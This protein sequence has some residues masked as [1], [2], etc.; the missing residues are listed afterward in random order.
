VSAGAVERRLQRAA[1]RLDQGLGR[2]LLRLLYRALARGYALYLRRGLLGTSVYL[3][4][5]MASGE[6]LHGLSDIDLAVIVPGGERGFARRRIRSRHELARR[7]L[8]LL[9]RFFEQPVIYDA[10][11][12]CETITR[13]VLTYGLDDGSASF[14]GLGD[15]HDEMQLERPELYGSPA[16]WRPL[17]GPDRRPARA[18]DPDDATCR[19][20]AWLELQNLW[21]WAFTAAAEPERPQNAYLCVKLI[22][23]GARIWLW[24]TARERV[25]TRAE[26]LARGCAELPDEAEAFERAR[27]LK[28][29]L[30]AMPRAPLAEFLPPFVRLSA[31]IADELTAQMAPAGSTVVRLVDSAPAGLILPHGGLAETGT[32]WP[33][34]TAGPLLALADFRALVDPIEPDETFAFVDGDPGHPETLRSTGLAADRG[35]YPTLSTR[36][37]MIRPTPHWGR[38]RLRAIQCEVSDPVSFALAAG[39]SAA[40]FPNVSGFSIHDTAQ[41]ALIEHTAWLRAATDQRS[42]PALGRLITAA[43]AG[44]LWQSLTDGD[45]ELALTVE[46]VLALLAATS[47]GASEIAE[48]AH[49]AYRDFAWSWGTPPAEIMHALREAVL[50]LPAY[51]TPLPTLA[52]PL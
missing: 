31:R 10:D 30:R 19:I 12:L 42:G 51:D 5:T 28:G 9:S 32:S 50:A 17:S 41:R 33:P 20:N 48:Q 8:P 16:L 14:Q 39:A 13:W 44:L 37:L 34:E 22:A 49:A 47:S 2:P 18:S 26:A 6:T 23:E 38:G 29:E 24:L 40:R 25:G 1:L 15:E 3:R 27:R 46:D 36:G 52:P 45:P 11:R 4:G 7:R 35:T 21:R 43:R